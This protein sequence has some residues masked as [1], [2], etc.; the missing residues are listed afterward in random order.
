MDDAD[1][2]TLALAM[3]D[4][5]TQIVIEPH[6]LTLDTIGV[7]GTLTATVIDAAGDTIDDAEVT[8]ESSDTTIAT[9][10]TAGVVTSVEFGKTKVSARY[11]SATAEATV[12]V[13]TPLT[14]REILEIFYEATG[15]D[16]WTDKTNWVSDEDL[17]EW[18]GVRAYQAKV[19]SLSL[20]EN[21]LVG[22]IRPE[23]GG[24]EELFSLS[25]YGN[26]LSGPIPAELSK[27]NDL[28]DLYL[29]DNAEISGRLPP[30][31]GYTGGLEYFS[32]DDTNLSGPVPLTFANLDLIRFYFDGEGVC[33]PAALEAWLKE[34]PTTEDDYELCTDQ[35]ALDPPSL[36]IEAP[37]LGDT[38]RLTAV[39]ISA[40]GDTVHDAAVTWSSAGTSNATVDSTGLVT[41]VEYG[42]T[43]VTATSDS[44]TATAE[45]EI[46]FKL[47]DRQVLDTLYRVTGGENWTDTTNWLSDEPLS[48][49][50]GVETNEAG[51]VTGLSLGSNNLTGSIPAVV[52]ELDDLVTLDLSGNALAGRIPRRLGELQQLRDLLLD[53]NALEGFLPRNLGYMAGL[54]YLHIGDNKLSG[55]VPRK[56]ARL[57]LDTLYA[58]GSGVCLP[59]SLS[60]WFTGIEQTDDADHCIASIDIDIVDLPSL[61]FYDPG[62]TG[63]LSATY[64]DAEGDTTHEASVTWSS[65]DTAVVSVSAVGRVTAVGNGETEVTATYDSTTGSIAVE[66]ALP[67]NDRDVLEILY[68][69]ARGDDWTEATNWLSDEP[70]SEWAGIETD[71]SGRVVGLSL[72]GNNVRGPIHSSIGQLDRLVTLDLSRN[73]ISG[74]IPAEVGDLSLLREL[75]LS[76]NGLVGELPGTLDSLRTFNVAAT[77][78]SG[79]VPASFADVELESFLVGGTELCVPPSLA[80]WLDSIA[81][82]DDPPECTSRVLL[83][84]SSLTFSEARDTARLSVTVIGPEGDVVESPAITWASADNRVA[85]VDTAG[86]VTAR[87]SGV[88]MATATYDTVT[89]GAAQVAVK[90]SGSDRVALE[91]F[92]RATGGDDWKDN[93][94][95][96]SDEPLGEWYGVAV[97]GSGRV[98]HLRLA[99][100]NLTGRIPAAIGLLDSL[101]ILT[102]RDTTLTGPI[103]PAIGLLRGLRDL[104]LGGTRIDGPVPPEMGNMTGL[105]YVYLSGTRLSGPSA[106]DTR[107]S[108]CGPVLHRELRRVPA[109]L[110]RRMVRVARRRRRSPPLY[111]GDRG[112]GCAGQPLQRDRRRELEEQ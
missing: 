4:D 1:S 112:P 40:E 97:D 81:E 79:L 54:R 19:S 84:P 44:L 95:W 90:L 75:A 27:F 37:P 14:D 33:I 48:E 72:R 32:I 36:Y 70:L 46:V 25:L 66:V 3:G 23:L 80:E 86:L 63:E 49:W 17:D 64:V 100:N 50:F 61:T 10:D 107:Q 56:F 34:I 5:S 12:E 74:S 51:K 38:A 43:Q 16:D 30:E 53:G 20:R 18:Y 106:R 39:V 6:W 22:A 65:G 76:V 62:E 59:P 41:S 8:W 108:R 13:A 58:A 68:N 47:S 60:E 57:E 98:R 101:L 83:E 11:D 26:K 31:L 103:P 89:T 88:T 78:L 111:P 71:D 87:S 69:R 110:P 28:R 92:Y 93:T 42:T 102:L 35:I 104:S 21:N 99:H 73:W 15:G 24:L 67:E 91:A 77:S 94:N 109:A 7:T 105:D 9:V 29:N 52:A 45:V 55:V 96:L 82:T 85:R 2:P